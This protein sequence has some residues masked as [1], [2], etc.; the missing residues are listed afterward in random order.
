MR[1]RGTALTMAALN[2]AVCSAFSAEAVEARSFDGAGA[3][4]VD[5]DFA[6]FEIECPSA[7]ERTY[8]GFCGAVDAE[9]GRSFY[10]DDGGVENDGAAVGEK[11]EG[12]LYGEEK[13]FDVGVEGFVVVGFGDGA[14]RCEFADAGVGEENVDAAF[15][16]L[17]GGV[18]AIEI[19]EI[20][21]V[22]LD[23]GDVFA[24]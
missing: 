19:G 15:L 22:A 16:L 3:D 9:R 21:D 1:P 24:D 4:D 13:A 10:G 2:W 5:A 17:D 7:G 11:R 20:G 8:G 14:E 18:E 12:F 6:V 23:G